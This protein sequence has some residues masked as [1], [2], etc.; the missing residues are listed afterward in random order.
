MLA[1]QQK[2][3]ENI[4]ILIEN[5]KL[6]EAKELTNQ[7]EKIEKDDI[8]IYSI[9]GVIALMEQDLDEAERVL[10]EGVTVNKTHFDINYN[11]GYLYQLKEK[12]QLAKE[13]YNNA[14]RNTES[15]TEIEDVTNI[16]KSLEVDEVG[17]DE[18]IEESLESAEEH[19]NGD[20]ITII[21]TD[22]M[23]EPSAG[24]DLYTSRENI[25]N[26]LTG[27]GEKTVTIVVQGYNR[28]DKTKYCVECVM[29]YTK[30]INYELVLI[31]NGS[32]D[33]TFEYFKSV[34]YHQKKVIKL[35]KNIGAFYPTLRYIFS[36]FTSKYLV[37]VPNDVYVTSNWLS[38]LITCMESDKKIGWVMPMSSNISNLQDPGLSFNSFEE[39]QQKAQEFNK[40]DPSKWQKRLRLV[41]P[42]AIYKKE[43][44]DLVGKFDVG[45]FHDFGEDDY[46]IR[47][48]R[49]GYRLILCGDT[50]VHHD[51]DFRNLEGKDPVLYKQ[52]LEKG[53]NNFKEKY[54]GLDAWD[55][56][57]NY[58]KGLINL[59]PIPK[60]TN[61]KVQILGID[62]RCGTPILEIENY[63][64]KNNIH[65]S[66]SSAFTTKSKYYFDLKTICEGNVYCDRIEY[67][68][69]HFKQ[70]YFDYIIIGEPINRFADPIKLLD[71]ILKAAKKGSKILFKL[72]NNNDVNKLLEIFGSK[73]ATNDNKNA[74]ISF[75]E[76]LEILNSK[77]VTEIKIARE[78]YDIDH[79]SIKKLRQS[80]KA[81]TMFEEVDEIL[82]E[83]LTKE[84]SFC[85]NKI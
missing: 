7:Y 77:K 68:N 67:I 20:N 79:P 24:S 42:L 74:S 69:D 49:M 47:L 16:L 56:I 14:L 38:N 12:I 75:N 62:V 81:I 13:Y 8:E 11:L 41:T 83:I 66:I 40:S 55:D 9:K 48:R 32:N 45:F 33:G 43:T 36:S 27:M 70:E 58:E 71:S 46:S 28:L 31:D 21:N 29:E 30:N 72:I 35:T 6:E 15:E 18:K 22:P 10:K 51:H 4:N 19:Q 85:I 3:K 2:I 23:E 78:K 65:N 84:Y 73:K 26:N 34:E 50:F 60:K 53:R 61:T 64:T 17:T 80:I 5:G 1:Y 44:I 63:L 76:L 25:Y 37:V 59:L 52:S 82:E 39:M 57:I 54:Y